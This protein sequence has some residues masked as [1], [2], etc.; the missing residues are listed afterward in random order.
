MDTEA[1]IGTDQAVTIAIKAIVFYAY[2][3]LLLR[4]SGKRITMQMTAFDFVSTVAMATIIGSTILQGTISLLEGIVAV[5]ALVAMQ[6]IAGQISARSPAIR[7]FLT[8]SPTLLYQGEAFQDENLAASRLSREQVMQKVRAA[9]HA[10]LST[11]SAIILESAGSV[12]VISRDGTE[13][14]LDIRG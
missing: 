12:S 11:V 6:W 5:T 13:Q 3:I 10:N 2:M 4:I 14:P 7:H 8:D 9:G 1:L